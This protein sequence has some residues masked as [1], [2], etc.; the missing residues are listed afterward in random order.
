MSNR[1]HILDCPIE[2]LKGIGP[3]R[4]ETLN[5]ELEVFTF[6]DLLVHF[7]FRYIDK[8]QLNKIGDINNDTPFVQLKGTISNIQTAGSQ[9][10]TR[11]TANF[12]DETGT[13]ELTWFKGVSY[14]KKFLKPNT[15]YLVY[16]KPRFFKYKF[17][18]AHPEIE[19]VESQEVQFENRLES[20]YP[21]TDKL[22][23][24]G[25]D[26]RGIHKA[27]KMLFEKIAPSD[28]S[29]NLPAQLITD[30]QLMDRWGALKNIHLPENEQQIQKAQFRLKFEDFFLYRCECC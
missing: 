1:S 16:G 24:K 29:E 10:T 26:S 12:S 14:M 30:Y 6:G 13:I 17:N 9:R 11:L 27:M 5:K 28:I 21:S 23:K 25:L 22:K 7:P 15:E 4:G 19:L 18:I 20:V 8:T 3:K 2:Y